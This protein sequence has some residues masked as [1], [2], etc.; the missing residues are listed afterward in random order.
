MTALGEVGMTELRRRPFAQL[1]GGQRQR[2]LIA[3]ALACEPELLL[4]D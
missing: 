4:L 2:V 1:S 3:R